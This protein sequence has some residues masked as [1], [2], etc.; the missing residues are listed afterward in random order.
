M[1]DPAVKQMDN[2]EVAVEDRIGQ[3]TDQIIH[4]AARHPPE[5]RYGLC[6]LRN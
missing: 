1:G 6:A 3:P 4:R 5:A 2:C